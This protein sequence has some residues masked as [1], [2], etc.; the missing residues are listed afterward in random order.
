MA[1]QVPS[2]ARISIAFALPAP[3]RF[4]RERG[5]TTSSY[6]DDGGTASARRAAIGDGVRARL[7]GNPMIERIDAPHLEIYGRH[8]FLS[9]QECA[10]LRMQIDA[11]ARP[12]SLFSG[13]SNPEYRT[14]SSCNLD[15][16]DAL[17]S[18][19]TARIVALTGVD[20]A[21]GETLQ[22]QRYEVGQ[23]YRPHCDYFPVTASYWPAMRGSG[24][25][26]CWTAMIY[27]NTVAEGGETH[28]LQSG[29]MIPPHEGMILVWNN[30][31]RDGA[32]NRYSL[33]AARPVAR[34]T[35]YVV[36]KWFRERPWTP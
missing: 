12:S 23:E 20:P 36:T 13:G 1:G 27:L 34:G 28:F 15:P 5:M 33:H 26:R 18:D 10:I 9:A 35:K 14:S 7:A 21:T 2:G 32:P 4:G 3:H 8:G 22:G 19:V 17:V 24:G 29:F 31:D 30:L 6:P 25:Q 16:W 11:G